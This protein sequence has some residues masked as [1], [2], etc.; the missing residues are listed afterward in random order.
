MLIRPQFYRRNEKELTQINLKYFESIFTSWVQ[1]DD[2]RII[3]AFKAN[4]RRGVV[5]HCSVKFV[6]F[7]CLI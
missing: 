4:Y 7:V 6:K 1:P 3:P 2:E 5:R